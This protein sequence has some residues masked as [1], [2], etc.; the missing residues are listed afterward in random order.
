[1]KAYWTGSYRGLWR[2]GAAL[3]SIVCALTGCTVED[4]AGYTSGALTVPMG[5]LP[6]SERKVIEAQ[7]WQ[8]EG[9]NPHSVATAD[10]R[11]LLLE[12]D[13]DILSPHILAAPSSGIAAVDAMQNKNFTV[14][15]GSGFVSEL[16]SLAPVGLLQVDG[17]TLNPVQGYGYTRILG[18]NDSGLGV[19]HRKDYQRALFHSALQA[20]PGIVENAE[21]DISVRDL[22]RPKYFRSFIGLCNSRWVVGVSLEPSHLRTLGQAFL[23]YAASQNWQCHDVVNLAGDRQAVLMLKAT[24]GDLL[25]HGDPNTYKVSLIGFE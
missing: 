11:L 7:N 17:E 20:G 24:N 23:E 2:Y 12:L 4:P 10:T 22:E 5:T 3:T 9:V 19:V 21:L 1:M 13:P 6:A 15:I 14:L 8:A 25:Y 16:N 18:I